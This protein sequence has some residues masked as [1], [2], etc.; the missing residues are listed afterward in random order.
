MAR[1]VGIVDPESFL[2]ECPPE[3]WSQWQAAYTVSPFGD[4]QTLLAKMLAALYLL[5]AKDGGELEKI[6]E[7]VNSIM[8]AFMP[9]G[10]KEEERTASTGNSIQNFEKLAQAWQP[11]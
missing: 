6:D 5:L 9:H 7:A 11:R 4:E 2:E 3:L 1:Q 8:V 10:W